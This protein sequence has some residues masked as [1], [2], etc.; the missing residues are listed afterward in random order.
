MGGKNQLNIKR[1]SSLCDK[2]F[3]CFNSTII[4]SHKTEIQNI[5]TI[6]KFVV[7]KT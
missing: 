3:T 1:K 6:G 7:V 5:V 2:M 4:L